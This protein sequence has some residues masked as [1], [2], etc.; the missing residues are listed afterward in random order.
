MRS[1]GDHASVNQGVE[2]AVGLGAKRDALLGDGAA[3]DD[4]EHALAREHDANRPARELRRCGRQD[5]VLPKKLAA[6]AAANEGRRQAHLIVFQPE[7]LRNRPGFVRHRLRSVVN[8]QRVA[9]PGEGAGVQLDR[10]VVMAG[11]RVHDVHLVRSG[12]KRGLG[13]AD[14]LLQR[15]AHEQAGLRSLRLGGGE[16]R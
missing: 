15:L 1:H 2:P 10:S 3:A 4:T 11:R 9:F 5:L 7:H 6:E 13:V 16:R 14:L 8:P 12:G